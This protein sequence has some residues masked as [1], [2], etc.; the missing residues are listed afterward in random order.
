MNETATIDKKNAEEQKTKVPTLFDNYNVRFLEDASDLIDALALFLDSVDSVIKD[1]KKLRNFAYDYR[2]LSY[3][4][5]EL[6]EIKEG[7]LSVEEFSRLLENNLKNRKGLN[8]EFS[9]LSDEIVELVDKELIQLI[10]KYRLA[11]TE[12]AKALETISKGLGDA[13]KL[14]ARIELLIDYAQR[15]IEDARLREKIVKRL[16]LIQKCLGEINALGY[17][18]HDANDW[19][20]HAHDDI[21]FFT[22]KIDGYFKGGLFKDREGNEIKGVDYFGDRWLRNGVYGS[23]ELKE[24]RYIVRFTHRVQEQIEFIDRLIAMLKRDVDI[25]TNRWIKPEATIEFYNHIDRYAAEFKTEFGDVPFANYLARNKTSIGMQPFRWIAILNGMK[26]RLTELMGKKNIAIANAKDYLT[27]FDGKGGIFEAR[28]K[29]LREVVAFLITQ[30]NQ[31]FQS[32]TGAI[33]LV[34]KIEEGIKRVEADV[35]GLWKERKVRFNNAYAKIV[36]LHNPLVPYFDEVGE[37]LKIDAEE[38]ELA[39]NGK[40]I[41]QFAEHKDKLIGMVQIQ[42]PNAWAYLLLLHFDF[43]RLG[44]FHKAFNDAIDSMMQKDKAIKGYDVSPIK[45]G[46]QPLINAYINFIR[47]VMSKFS[48][49]DS[50]HIK[51]RISKFMREHYG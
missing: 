11:A 49:E 47:W 44:E 8:P 25:K 38:E 4:Q 51:N 2:F 1:D 15:K 3:L 18:S 24:L 41:V 21:I 17:C 26:Q 22:G 36:D 9:Q 23:R 19:T 37:L 40:G 13:E 31:I 12:L 42:D 28:V 34:K 5:G 27:G 16:A 33:A 46:M 14:P 35:N 50:D 39:K 48:L 30:I 32:E 7:R 20:L 10:A 45:A 43:A 6:R 29:K